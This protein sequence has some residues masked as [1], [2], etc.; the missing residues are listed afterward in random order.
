[1]IDPVIRY[2]TQNPCYKAGKTIAVKGLMLHSIGTPQP[3]PL[4]FIRNWNRA[5]YDRACV[6][7]FIG[8]DSVYIT[9]PCTETPGKAMR[10]WHGG[11][12]SNN[13]HIG[14]EMTEPSVIRYTGG[15]SFTVLDRQA[16]VAFVKET[17]RNAVELF[18][19]LCRFHK[20]DPLADGVII[21]HAEGHKRGIASN[22]GD[23]DHLWRQLGMDYDMDAFRREVAE[24]IKRKD[25]TMTGEE[26]YRALNEYLDKHELPDWA[27][28]EFGRAIDAGITDGTHPMRLIPRYQAAIMALRAHEMQE[29]EE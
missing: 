9:L 20:L 18:A 29:T 16:A 21:S 10:G 13:T 22:H 15:A 5:D 12:S 19:E 26:I 1:M 2:L 28:L 17:T 4:V 3:D 8:R 23:P 6:H 24:E 14:I 11:G 27:E 25:E 7:G